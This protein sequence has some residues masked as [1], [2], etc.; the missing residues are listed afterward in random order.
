MGDQQ[1]KLT[2]AEIGWLTGIIEGEGSITMNARKKKWKGWQGFG[3]DMGVTMCNTDAGIIERCV[4][5]IRKMGIE[6]YIH[7][8]AL[9]PIPYRGKGNIKKTYKSK[10]TILSPYM[11]GEKKSRADLIVEFINRRLKRKGEHSKNGYGR[12]KKGGASSWMNADDWKIVRNFYNING[13]KLLP[14]VQLFLND[15]TQLKP[16]AAG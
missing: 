8:S 9:S 12:T 2:Q 13:G 7:E 1:E 15:H 11:A 5:I 16:K 4:Q 10:G 6:P 14:E 3:V